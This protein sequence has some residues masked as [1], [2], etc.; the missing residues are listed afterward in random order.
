MSDSSLA[1]SDRYDNTMNRVLAI[2]L[3]GALCALWTLLPPPAR[4]VEAIYSQG[5]FPHLA[6]WL[7]PLTSA[8]PFSLSLVLGGVALLGGA[9]WISWPLMRGRCW[10]SIGRLISVVIIGYAWFLLVWGANYQRAPLEERLALPVTP[11]TA[12]EVERMAARLVGIIALEAEAERDLAAAL[13]SGLIALQATAE[14]FEGRPVTLPERVKVTPPGLLLRAGG[15]VGVLSPWLLEPHVDGALPDFQH[16]A[17]AM[18]ELAHAAGYAGEAETDLV[19]ALAGL[20]ASDPFMRY[21][22]ALRLFETF[23]WQLPGESRRAL[24]AALPPRAQADLAQWHAALR[25]HQAPTWLRE[26]QTALY[27]RYLRSQGVAEGIAD[28]GRVVLLLIAAERASL[29]P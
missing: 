21:S 13:A 8:V 16:L 20:A 11:V 27:D 24:Q 1:S 28:Y 12:T 3:L 26:L 15:A 4:M 17:V 29:A 2:S 5:L 10:L 6:A 25:Q 19:A 7:I 22:T 18:H 9:L 23:V 14:R